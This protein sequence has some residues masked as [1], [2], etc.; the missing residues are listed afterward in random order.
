MKFIN[1]LFCKISSIYKNDI[2]FFTLI[3]ILLFIT[4][5]Y[6]NLKSSLYI[7]SLLNITNAYVLATF[8]CLVLSFISHI[9]T[10]KIVKFIITF[11]LVIYAIIN[12][13]SISLTLKQ[14]D[15]GIVSLIFSTNINET[16]EFIKSYISAWHII[17]IIFFVFL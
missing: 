12:Y 10:R 11:F 4:D 1:K 16:K 17:I 2:I 5:A 13:Y 15:N 6:Y 3:F 8:A 7:K 14:F 9:V